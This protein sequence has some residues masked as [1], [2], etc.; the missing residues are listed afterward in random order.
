MTA[1]DNIARHGLFTRAV[2]WTVAL[3]FVL[4]LLTG[5]PVW[6]PVFGWMASIFGGLTVCRWLHAWFGIAFAAA[7]LVMFL[8]WAG[9]MRYRAEDRGFRLFRYL[10]A[11]GQV[12]PQTGK[13]NAGQ[14]LFFWAASL[15]ALGFLASGVVLWWPLLFSLPLRSAAVLVHDATFILFFFAAVWH[16]YLGTAAEPGTFRAMT[17]GTVTKPWAQTHH[18]GWLREVER[19][20]R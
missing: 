8:H 5:L 11:G 20:G 7:S 10:G 9:A 4:S 19:G 16:V 15:G 13:Y 17:R 14:K 12:D 2:H 18:P 6:S 3:G 1:G